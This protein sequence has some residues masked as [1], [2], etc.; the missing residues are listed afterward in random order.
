MLSATTV[1]QS[2]AFSQELVNQGKVLL[3]KQGSLLEQLV[4]ASTPP[5]VIANDKDSLDALPAFIEASTRNTDQGIS[6]HGALVDTFTH[7]LSEA[8][9]SHIKL[10]KTTVLPIVKEATQAV[11]EKHNSLM[12]Q[13]ALNDITIRMHKKPM[14]TSN[15]DLLEMLT[16]YESTLSTIPTFITLKGK[17]AAEIKLLCTTGVNSLDKEVIE[18]LNGTDEDIIIKIYELLYNYANSVWSLDEIRTTNGYTLFTIGVVGYLIGRRLYDEVDENVAMSLVEYQRQIAEIRDYCAGIIKNAVN[19]IDGYDRS[20]TVVVGINRNLKTIDVNDSL[21]KEWVENNTEEAIL[22]NL[23]SERVYSTFE[24]ITENKDKLV[25]AW[26]NYKVYLD[27]RRTQDNDRAIRSFIANV[28]YQDITEDRLTDIEKE[29][30]VVDSNYMVKAKQ[31]VNDYVESL[32]ANDMDNL[33]E[34]VLAA[35][36]KCRF[37]FTAAYDILNGMH[38][39]A[40]VNPDIDPR[41][42]ALI[43]VL[44]YVTDYF[45][46]Q[47]KVENF[48]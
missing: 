39:V 21:Y 9:M 4:S 10:A 46:G 36:A 30:L 5:M 22:G 12:L 14:L 40:K 43:S 19:L 27:L 48:N 28:V 2:A 47:V 42:A 41:E 11:I 37:Y 33:P 45:V 26:K 15:S 1:Q 18:Y 8:V 34:V 31:C 7:T 3:P 29:Y 35:V 20:R 25:E 23:V 16:N 32:S 24:L 38:E 44:Y 17:N 6:Q 13:D